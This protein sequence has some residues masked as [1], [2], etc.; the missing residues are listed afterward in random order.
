L[1][2]NVKISGYNLCTGCGVCA[3]ICPNKCINVNI[4]EFGFL[5][6]N[7]N[8]L[9]CTKCGNCTEVC[10]KY[11][12][13]DSIVKKPIFENKRV[14]AAVNNYY[15]QS[16]S[17]STV[18]VASSLSSY[19]YKNGYNVCG[20]IFKPDEDVC[21]HIIAKD[22]NDIEKFKTSKYIQ[23]NIVEA[24]SSIKKDKKTIVFG[25]P[26]QI[27]GVR[28]YTEKRKIENHF[29]L[30]DLFC[31]GIPSFNLWKA[32]KSFIQRN[33]KLVNFDWIN[34]KEKSRGWHNFSVNIIDKNGNEYIQTYYNDMFYSFYLRNVCLNASCYD[35]KLR[36]NIALSDIRLGDFWGEKYRQYKDGVG[37]V[38]LLS[39]MGDAVWSHVEKY[40]RFE[41]CE[42]SDI[43]K[44]QRINNII[45][46]NCYNDVL[47]GLADGEKLEDIHTAYHLNKITI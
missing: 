18:G 14:I 47:K 29:V 5:V 20:V 45:I 34:F 12:K 28:K 4:N 40:F 17:V 8:E 33:F 43:L 44:S 2:D 1:K 38:V 19:Y 32:Y 3:V 16:N 21:Q 31:R 10:Y 27:F 36:H 9:K 24:I 35:C 15:E 7:I 23:S 6:P 22:M 26:C 41:E 46:P 39:E 13:M 37:L 11:Y 30:V 25:T 42:S